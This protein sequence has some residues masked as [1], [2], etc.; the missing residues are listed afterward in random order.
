MSPALG[1]NGAVQAD[2]M[3]KSISGGWGGGALTKSGE[4]RPKIRIK[5]NAKNNVRGMPLGPLNAD[6]C[7]EVRQPHKFFDLLEEKRCHSCSS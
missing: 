4:V 2:E 1:A 6:P 7:Y 5:I 3:A